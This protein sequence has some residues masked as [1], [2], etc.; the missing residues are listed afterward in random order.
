MKTLDRFAALIKGSMVTGTI[1]LIPVVTSVFIVYRTFRWLDN[2]LPAIIPGDLPPGIGL[3]GLVVIV[4]VTGLTAKNYFGKHLIRLGTSILASIP[5]LNRVYLTL[6]QIFDLMLNPTKGFGGKVV[7]VQ[8]PRPGT[9]T[10]GFVT[11]TETQEISDAVGKKLICVYIPTTPNPTSGFMAYVPESDVL[12]VKL[13]SEVALKAVISAGIVSSAQ[14]RGARKL[15]Y[16]LSEL[17]A[18]W[19]SEA[20]R[21]DPSVVTDPRD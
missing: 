14:G 7:L 17:I 2:I 1:I 4:L 13:S 5:I 19:K 10:L 20:R 8:Y 3:V 6:Q 11:S 12:D 18:Q 15:D 9:W 16:S 21:I